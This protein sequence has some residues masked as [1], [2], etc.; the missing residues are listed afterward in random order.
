MSVRMDWRRA[1]FSAKRSLSIRDEA[2][3]RDHDAASR[4]LNGKAKFMAAAA[5][6]RSKR[7]R[8]SS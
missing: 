7:R 8:R 6:K 1:G 2:D 4:W 3:Y 5:K